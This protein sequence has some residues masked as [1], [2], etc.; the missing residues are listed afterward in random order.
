[1]QTSIIRP[2]Q[3]GSARRSGRETTTSHHLIL[4]KEANLNALVE[5]LDGLV[6]SIDRNM[7][8]II[9]NNALRSKI[10]EIVGVDPKPG[11]KMLDLLAVLDPSK[12]KEWKKLY[13]LGFKGKSQRTLQKFRIDGQFVFFDISINPIRKGDE[14][15]GLS[16][17]ARDVTES[18]N[19]ERKLKASEIRFRSLI[20]KSTDIILLLDAEGKISYGSPSIENHFGVTPE[21][22]IGTSG[23]EYIPAE[24]IPYASEK[25]M[26]LVK[27][28]GKPIF[29][30]TKIRRKDGATIWIEGVATNLLDSEGI[31]GIV[32]NFRDVT[33][34]KEAA[35]AQ[36]QID[37]KFRSL[38]E[39]SA[40][41]IMMA[42]AE[43]EFIYGSPSVKK[44]LG[45][46]GRDY[47]NKNIFTFIHPDS[48]TASQQ[49]LGSLFQHPG[50]AFTIYLSLLHKTGKEVLV[51]GIA[52]NFL[53]VPG[54]NALVANFRDI[55]ERKNAEKLIRESEELYKDLFDKSPLP[56]WVCDA[57]S[58][59]FLEA[60]EAAVQ[61][62][63]YSR[64]EFLKLTAFDI[65]SPEDHE[66]LKRLLT[67]GRKTVHHR[68]LR[69]QVKKNS[70]L[71]YVEVLTHL[72]KYKDRDSYLI[73]AN[74]ITEKVKLR[75]QLMEE[76]IYRQKEIMKA[77]ID[78]QEKEREEIGRELHDNV[79]Q[80]LTTARLCLSCVTDKIEVPDN[81]I[82]RSSDIIAT[83]IEE[84]R[85]L[86]KSLTQTYHKEIGLQLSIEDLVESIRLA[87]QFQIT[88]EFSVPDEQQLDDK[89]KMTLFR[90]VQEQLNNI[91]KHA[92]ASQVT[93]SVT[94]NDEALHLLITDNGRGFNV[95]EKK[96]G[97]GITNII[98]RADIFN[99]R[100]KIDSSPGRGCRMSVHFKVVAT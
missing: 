96:N 51:E 54:I 60:N 85:K 56:I 34:R 66:E 15:T 49:L 21:E 30:Q 19:Y 63:G 1:M 14:V 52:T 78:A 67:T 74:D 7:Q 32:C 13:Q 42:N 8:Y 92:H 87:R 46:S 26:E 75:H 64:K 94:Q 3:P 10:K 76:K 83:A 61:H 79:T 77:T 17:L 24:E 25:F 27:K 12:T 18:M 59:R 53:E 69:K 22:Y 89:L 36:R 9:L 93:I 48:I 37:L 40:D 99:G 35:E 71:I 23:F 88:L 62:Y 81:M 6:W 95:R 28:P 91:L 86:S 44:M 2:D 16:C 82:E 97:I 65:T 33:E 80:I 72:I 55:T 4:E 38:I 29:I 50:K 58:F 70:E 68:L 43:G 41:L 73:L 31:H 57:D 100:V 11:D 47:L 98:N 84:I 90:I 20:E 5:H 39:N 45:Y